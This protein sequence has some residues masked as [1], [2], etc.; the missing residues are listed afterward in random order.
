M[1][2]FKTI[3]HLVKAMKDGEIPENV[4]SPGAA[5]RALGVTRQAINDRLHNTESL[6]A[7]SAESVI[8]ISGRSLAAAVKKK[9]GIPAGQGELN[10]TT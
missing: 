5:A 10:V 3:G 6:E 9:R 2:K 8:L 1:K 4:V 7:W